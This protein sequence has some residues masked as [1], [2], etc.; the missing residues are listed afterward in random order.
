[1]TIMINNSNNNTN[2]TNN[3]NMIK[4]VVPYIAPFNYNRTN[5]TIITSKICESCNFENFWKE[6]ERERENIVYI[7]IEILKPELNIYNND[8]SNELHATM[9]LSWTDTASILF[10]L[11]GGEGEAAGCACLFINYV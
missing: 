11:N 1:M 5:S 8:D 7:C 2:N 3:N 4:V 10:F 6:R 9:S